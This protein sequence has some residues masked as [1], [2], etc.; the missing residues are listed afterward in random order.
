MR[1]DNYQIIIIKLC[2]LSKVNILPSYSLLLWFNSPQLYC[3]GSV[4]KLC[5]VFGCTGSYVDTSVHYKFSS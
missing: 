3:L 4:W 5:G 2:R 1:K